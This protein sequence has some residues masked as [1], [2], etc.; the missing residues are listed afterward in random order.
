VVA[1]VDEHRP[2][3]NGHQGADGKHING[4]EPK[5]KSFDFV[6]ILAQAPR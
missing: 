5:A 2:D 1:V 3:G 6:A 4:E